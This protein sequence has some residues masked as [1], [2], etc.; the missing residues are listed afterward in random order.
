MG[1]GWGAWV[2]APFF[3]GLINGF[4][5]EGVQIFEISK[6]IRPSTVLATLVQRR[7]QPGTSWL[8]AAIRRVD[9]GSRVES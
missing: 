6:L 1:V 9:A 2:G 3:P 7:G 4:T 8:V 5:L